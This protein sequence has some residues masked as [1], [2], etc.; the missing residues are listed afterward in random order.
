MSKST[1]VSAPTNLLDMVDPSGATPAHIAGGGRG[2]E[3]V[4]SNVTIPRIKQLQKMSSET[5]EHSSNYVDGAKPGDLINSLTG[6]IYGN[7]VYVL[8]LTFKDTYVVWGDRNKSLPMLSP[9]VFDTLAEAEFA[10]SQSDAPDDYKATQTHSHVMLVKDPATGL[11]ESTPVI[12]DF[13]VSKMKISKDWNS[14]I[15]MK[16]GDRFAGL[17][18]LE[19]ISQANKAGQQFMNLKAEFVGW[20]KEEDYEAA[21]AL[22]EAYK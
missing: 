3:N 1:A 13:S 10:I 22:Y 12:M 11:L 5:D 2:N 18:K 17:W 21:E 6:H 20:A 8:P 4:G 15:A 7:A 16:G 14:Q 19:S 9:F